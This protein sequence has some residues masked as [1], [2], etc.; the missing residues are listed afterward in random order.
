MSHRLRR[1]L[2]RMTDCLQNQILPALE[3]HG[4]RIL[5]YDQLDAATTRAMRRYFEERVFPVL[6]PLAIDKGHPFPYISNLS[7][8][9]AVELEET[10]PDGPIRYVARV[11]VPG[12]LPRFVPVESAP[13]GQRWF[14]MLE[15]V[16]AHNLEALFPGLRVTDS[17]LFRV[18]RDADLDLQEDEADDLLRAIESELRKRRFGEP[19]RLEVEPGMPARAEKARCSKRSSSTTATATRSTACSAPPTCGRSST[20][21]SPRCTIRRSRRRSPSG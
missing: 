5:G 11:K 7:I 18:T 8:S 1:S 14:V 13:R 15:D 2:A 17:Y 19:V 3:R 12:S 21:T 16:I 9:L 6:T 10:T 20:S 4:I